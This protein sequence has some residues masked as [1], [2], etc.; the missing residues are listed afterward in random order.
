[1]SSTTLNDKVSFLNVASPTV[2]ANVNMVTQKVVV[3]FVGIIVF[4]FLW[5]VAAQNIETSLGNFPGPSAVM[6][7]FKALYSEHHAERVKESAF[8]ER[9]EKR[10]AERVAADPSYEPKIRAYT[11]KETFLD[12]IFTS[13]KTVMAGF[14]VA[15]AI[16]IPLGIAIGL[17]KCAFRPS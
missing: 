8:F 4:L 16:A 13:L 9:Q 15:A 10:N 17:S 12:Q 3:P 11:G 14:I 6:T 2:K 5:S 7:Q 1:M